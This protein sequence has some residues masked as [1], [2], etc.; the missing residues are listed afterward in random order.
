MLEV[1]PMHGEGILC[2]EAV[3]GNVEM[4]EMH[5]VFNSWKNIIKSH[6]DGN[7]KKLYADMSLMMDT[8]R[9]LG[10]F[11]KNTPEGYCAFD[12]LDIENCLTQ[13]NI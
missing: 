3:I 6:K 11:V 7:G 2:H 4:H 1:R 10:T 12:E 5:R 13:F 9:I 8:A